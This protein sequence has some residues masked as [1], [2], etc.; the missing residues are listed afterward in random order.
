[1]IVRSLVMLLD[2]GV[3]VSLYRYMCT[4]RYLFERRL[5]FVSQVLRINVNV[6]SVLA[7][8]VLDFSLPTPWYTSF[9]KK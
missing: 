2:S 3:L 5:I 7:N 4:Q 1:M 8:L 6:T 9:P